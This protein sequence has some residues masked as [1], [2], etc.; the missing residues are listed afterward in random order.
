M[1]NSL[2]Q[3]AILPVLILFAEAGF[4]TL[5][6]PPDLPGIQGAVECRTSADL[7]RALKP[8]RILVWRHGSTF[9]A[10]AWPA[11]IRFLEHGGSFLHLGGEPFTRPVTGKPGARVVQPRTLSL[12]EALRL[13]R[14]CRIS[15]GGATVS[16]GGCG[17]KD[18]PPDF[19]VPP[20]AHVS[21][22][23]PRFADTRDFAH[24]DGA[25]GVR[26][27][28]LRPLAMARRP[29]GDP[30]FPFA[31]AAYAV[32][33]LRGRFAGGRW[34]FRLLSSPVVAEELEF[35]IREARR[36]PL[37]LR[38][39]PTF[40]CFHAGER[41]SV[42]VRV[43]R[44][45]GGEVRDIVF[46]L[47]VRG[48]DGKR[49]WHREK[50]GV[51]VGMHG[52]VE[53][54]LDFD[55]GPGLYRVTA[56]PQGRPPVVTGFWVFDEALFRSGDALTFDGYTLRRNGVAE[57]VIGT[58]VMSRSVHRKFLFE[59]NAAEWDDTFAELA[60]LK[61]NLVRT[62]IWS[63]FRK[64]ALDPGV[65]D[66]AWLRALEAFYL[67]ARK[68]GIPVLFTFFA[69]VPE[70]FGGENPYLDPRALEGQRAYLSAVASR[71]K[72]AKEMLWDLINEPSFS[73]PKKLWQCRPTG[74]RFERA[75]FLRWL[76]QRYG[77]P[78][79]P[80]D[81][82]W[83]NVVRS[84][85][86]LRPDEAIGLPD[87]GDFADRNVFSSH[88]PYRAR[89]Y[90]HFAQDAFEG[91]VQEMTAAL[92]EAGSSAAVTVGQ[93]EGGLADRP[94]PLFHH[95]SVDFTSMHTWWLNDALYWDGLMARAPGKP[96]L[97]SETGV[98]HRERLS[99]EAHRTPEESARLLERKI[100]YAFAAGAFGVVQWCYD[101][102]PYMDSDNEAAIGLR[103]VDGSYK[104][105]HRV[106]CDF[107]AFFARNRR[108]FEPGRRVKARIL[109]FPH[110]DHFS[111][112]GLQAKGTRRAV[113]AF[114]PIQVVSEY[115][116]SEDLGSPEVIVLPSCRGISDEAWRDIRAAVERGATLVCS[117]WFEADDAGLPAHRLGTA[118]APLGRRPLSRVECV[119]IKDVE[120]EL[121]FP[122]EITESAY[123]ADCGHAIRR[124]QLGRGTVLHHPVP[125]DWAEPG[126]GPKL[127]YREVVPANTILTGKERPGLEVYC[128]K[129]R[130]ATFIVAVNTG[131]RPVEDLGTI[132]P[133]RVR[134]FL[135][136]A[137]GRIMDRSHP[138]E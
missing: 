7:E 64:I 27:A 14:C 50:I 11:L 12:L 43:H 129:L 76:K 34:M 124:F 18:V 109:V 97:V 67:T 78:G 32:D 57:P 132:P 59:P 45:R 2:L 10:E 96:L 48:P 130:K 65:V 120:A 110:G 83:Q 69:F 63:G 16:Y 33:R 74:D 92:R 85:W 102:N 87:E 70:A 117:G 1:Q 108:H 75:A 115:R 4:P 36:A 71:F 94:G 68:H 95:R 72:G 122:R 105:E 53:V 61:I 77:Q 30:R 131:S 80:E 39:D 112:R 21:V 79:D 111:P 121:W 135:Y 47:E 38:V 100:G 90:C 41:P 116:T 118:A 23:E 22:L 8:G 62:G 91:W 86:R 88:R 128:H 119:E 103:R 49:V 40:G 31:A 60:S 66:E 20:G 58:T 101:A 5:G 25:P 52:T 99:G 134:M 56:A 37:D 123:A 84:R 106:L 127:W 73:N 113:E 133:G 137:K 26:D 98:M 93:D 51:R 15:A 19:R 44:P 82:A 17:L 126:R 9:P 138:R 13:N 35:L 136:D 55:A 81:T 46:D 89:D 107:A 42:Q 104:C 24:K 114:Q 6:V 3:A 54:P 125:V 28:I 29:G